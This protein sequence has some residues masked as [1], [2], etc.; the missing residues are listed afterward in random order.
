MIKNLKDADS[1]IEAL[2]ERIKNL[3]SKPLLQETSS[4]GITETRIADLEATVKTL[5]SMLSLKCHHCGNPA[6]HQARVMLGG[7]YQ[8]LWCCSTCDVVRAA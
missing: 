3:E 5:V 1:E 8:D 2:K 6:D 4:D 7:F